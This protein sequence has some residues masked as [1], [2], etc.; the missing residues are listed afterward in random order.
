[1]DLSF[2][3]GKKNSFHV[4]ISASFLMA[5]A[6]L[7]VALHGD[8]NPPG[9]T[10]K[11]EVLS[12]LGWTPDISLEKRLQTLEKEGWAWFDISQI[13]PALKRMLDLRNELGLRSVFHTVA[14]LINP[15]NAAA[16]IVGISH[17]KSFQKVGETLSA[18]GDSYGLIIRGLEGESELNLSGPVEGMLVN[19]KHVVRAH[20]DPSILHFP[21]VRK[22][23]ILLQDLV[24][25]AGTVE[26]ILQGTA[27][28]NLINMALWNAAA[29]LYVSRKTDSLKRA[30]EMVK[31]ALFS[32]EAQRRLGRIMTIAHTQSK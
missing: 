13:H 6:G 14:R 22:E 31:N 7:K 29:G 8:P 32:G 24:T 30:L 9:R 4:G 3:A 10:S 15:L 1:I 21:P 2:Y 26:K 16:H 17:P 5:A 25:E 19:G 28:E 18:I 11:S 12:R 27:D 20:F 23:R